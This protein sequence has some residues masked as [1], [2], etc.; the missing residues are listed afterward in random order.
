[1]GQYYLVTNVSKKE[2]IHPHKFGDGLK[3]LEFGCSAN[4]TMTALAVLL[5]HGNGRGGGDLHSENEIIGSWAG[6]RIV[7]SGDYDDK[8]NED[9]FKKTGEIVFI[10]D[11]A[12]KKRKK[13]GKKYKSLRNLYHIAQDEWK[14]ISIDVIRALIDDNWIKQVYASGLVRDDFHISECWP[15]D[16][17]G[18]LSKMVEEIKK[19]AGECI[20][21][22]ISIDLIIQGF[23]EAAFVD[24]D[25]RDRITN[26]MKNVRRDIER[27][28]YPW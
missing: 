16:L 15:E 14:D 10:D 28:S 20:K 6:D 19:K 8:F 23:V 12:V 25:V 1:M 17:K 26:M 2:F 5:S 3:L 21:E 13:S 27:G 9:E 4:G 18:N 7:I 22:F 11:D 24:K